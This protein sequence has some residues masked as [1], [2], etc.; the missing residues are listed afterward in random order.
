[1]WFDSYD[2]LNLADDR[3]ELFLEDKRND[4]PCP[5]DDIN[6]PFRADGKDDM[7]LLEASIG[8]YTFLGIFSLIYVISGFV[9]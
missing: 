2:D 4:E 5:V 7:R 6:D 3:L 8:V 1:M 9:Y